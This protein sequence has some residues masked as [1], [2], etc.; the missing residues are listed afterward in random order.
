[1]TDPA[2]SPTLEP[3]PVVPAPAPRKKGHPVLAWIAIVLLVTISVWHPWESGVSKKGGGP[4]GEQTNLVLLRLQGRY[5]VGAEA[6]LDSGG[7]A[8]LYQQLQSIGTDSVPQRLRVA[9]LGGELIGPEEAEKQLHALRGEV[10]AKPAEDRPE[11]AALMGVLER[12]YRDYHDG[13]LDAPSVSDA[14]RARV[15]QELGWFG[16]LAL[17]PRDGPDR[18]ARAAVLAPAHRTALVLVGGLG[19]L[20][21]VGLF[22]LTGLVLFLVLLFAG[23]LRE[24]LPGPYQYGGVYAETFA[25]WMALFEGLSYASSWVRVPRDYVL[26]LSGAV[27]LV[28]L[29][30]ALCWP[31]LRGVPWAR[32][33]RDV[34]LNFGRSPALEPALGVACYAMALPLLVLGVLGTLLLTHLQQWWHTTYHP[35]AGPLLPP[36]HPV[37]GLM[38]HMDW[39]LLLQLLF[40]ASVAAPITEETMFRGLLY[41]HLRELTG[42]W[43]RAASLLFSALIVSF[44]FAVIHPQGWTA[45]PALMSLA[46]GF[47]LM[48]EWR[49]TL[50]PSM[51]AHGI[52][53][54]L[55]MLFFFFALGG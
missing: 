24:G 30:L 38:G 19:T 5:V 39:R 31:L 51:I 13:H 14:E 15:R 36:T 50:I 32:L 44:V 12:L 4:G 45:V 48:R 8:R 33:R 37:V 25:V 43:G 23:W 16:E 52:N 11:D 6:L 40:L 29:L 17:A 10:A 3:P 49:G 28:C 34:G 35:D 7:R 42:R 9:V 41:R 54:G 46:L 2:D 18:E 47:S 26:V 20:A 21:G 53:N 1:M 27:S 55:L 22:G